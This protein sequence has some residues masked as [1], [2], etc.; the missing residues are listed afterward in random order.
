MTKNKVKALKNKFF[1][2]NKESDD[3]GIESGF[4]TF[5]NYP[6]SKEALAFL[7]DD[8]TVGFTQDYERVKFK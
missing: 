1:D 3:Q 7:N 8:S 2:K 4:E 5:D 6:K